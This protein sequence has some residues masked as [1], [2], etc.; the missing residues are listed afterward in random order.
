MA[1]TSNSMLN[2]SSE[3]WNPCL[4]SEFSRKAFS[5]SPLSIIWL[6]VALIMLRYVPSMSC[7]EKYQFRSS[8]H[9]FIGFFVV[10]IK[11]YK[12]FVYFGN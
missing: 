1:R 3:S 4:V 8:T 10:I 6:W 7:L 11:Q 5:F 12:L 2:R 9:F